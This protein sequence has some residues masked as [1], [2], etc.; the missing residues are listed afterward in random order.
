VRNGWRRQR[1]Q[2]HGRSESAH[3]GLIPVSERP[4]Y[5]SFAWAYDEVVPSPAAPQP[6]DAAR[7]FAGRHTIVDA[8]C[9]TGR[10]SAFLADAGFDVIGVDSSPAMIEVARARGSGARFEVGDLL[11]WRPPAPVDG[12]LCRGVLNDCTEDEQRQRGLDSLF[13]MLRPGGLLVLSVR[14]IEK[15]RARYGREPVLTRSADG[16]FFR[17][18]ARFVGDIV[19]VDETVSSD[20]ARAEYRFEMRPWSLTEVDERGA[21]AGFSRVERRIEGDRILA[22]CVR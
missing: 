6:E 2:N 13:Q 10:H 3:T 19:V 18:E 16:V 17:T 21:A 5:T 14:E 12:V 9:G 15:T 4:I 8:G 20:D 7:L 22:A 1:K 11:T